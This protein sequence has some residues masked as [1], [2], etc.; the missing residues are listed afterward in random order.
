M[1]LFL[2]R[3]NLND[4]ITL[5]LQWETTYL[6]S[7]PIPFFDVECWMPLPPMPEGE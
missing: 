5:S 4:E 3:V 7:K 1:V 6:P 2:N